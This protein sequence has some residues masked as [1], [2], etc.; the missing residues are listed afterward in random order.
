LFGLP[1]L[2]GGLVGCADDA[3]STPSLLEII[4]KASSPHVAGQPIELEAVLSNGGY[5]AYLKRYQWS[6]A[7]SQSGSSESKQVAIGSQRTLTFTPDEPGKYIA[8]CSLFIEELSLRDSRSVYLE[9]RAV[10]AVERTYLVRIF[11]PAKSGLPPLT[12]ELVVAGVNKTVSWRA[13]GVRSLALSVEYQ[14][15]GVDAFVQ[16]ATSDNDPSPRQVFLPAGQGSVSVAQSGLSI[17]AIPNDATIPPELHRNLN[18]GS[19]LLLTLG[20]QPS[21][22]V[23]G[24]VIAAGKPV[25]GAR[26]SLKSAIS[27]SVLTIPSTMAFSDANGDVSVV[28]TGQQIS[29]VTIAPDQPGWPAAHVEMGSAVA[30]STPFRFEYAQK[31]QPADVGL[32]LLSSSGMPV[33]EGVVVVDSVDSGVIGTL[34]LGGASYPASARFRRELKTGASGRLLQPLKL[35]AGSYRFE[36]RPPPGSSDGRTVIERKI[37]G[38]GALKLALNPRSRVRGVV[39]DK[40]GSPARARI[41]LRADESRY[42]TVVD[43]AG[44]FELEVDQGLSYTAI[45]RPTD[46]DDRHGALIKAGITPQGGPG[47]TL[48]L[49]KAIVVDGNLETEAEARSAER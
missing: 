7:K 34:R 20:N 27:G 25:A 22:V 29:S 4:V 26:V 1:L 11:P 45:A 6:I 35:V 14:S 17:V 38:A 16:L 19:S 10:D 9:V 37:T 33:A 8:T 23:T 3:A 41:E 32:E 40:D 43:A 39:L 49:P 2:L 42:A 36:L 12:E 48:T 5:S 15:R 46:D 21:R 47:L 31:P 13:G 28:T 30:G 44:R 24:A 18:A